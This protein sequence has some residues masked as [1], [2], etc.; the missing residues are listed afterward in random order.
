MPYFALQ[1]MTKIY[2]EERG[3]GQ[4][5]LIVHGWSGSH[6]SMVNVADILKDHCRCIIYDHRGHGVSDKPMGGYSI[7]QLARDLHELVCY[8][9]LHDFVLAGHS[10][11]GQVVLSYV[12]QFGCDRL[13]RLM[14]WDMS[15]RIITDD[16]WSLGI[17][18]SY[19]CRE[20]IQDLH[21]MS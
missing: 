3:K 8:L 10:M 1:D 12:E 7:E 13:A 9:D 6:E 19:S 18:G 2:Y 17:N 11:G 20:L 21:L 4:P 15:P 16:T 14:I 5:V